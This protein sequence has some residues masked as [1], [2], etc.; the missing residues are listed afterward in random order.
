MQPVSFNGADARLVGAR[1]SN[2][3]DREAAAF[4]YTVRGRRVTVMVF[5]PPD[6]LDRV[7]QRTN[8]R[9]QNM[10]YGQ[11]HGYTVPVVQHNGLSYAFTGDL[12]SRSLMQLAATARLGR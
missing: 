2:V 8:V 3:S 5:E 11:A 10:Y 1:I 7:A 6:G 9:G 4:Y 12:D